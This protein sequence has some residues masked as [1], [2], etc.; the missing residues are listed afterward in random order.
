[1]RN[2]AKNGRSETESEEDILGSI[3]G[4]MVVGLPRTNWKFIH[5][6]CTESG[7]RSFNKFL[8]LF[9]KEESKKKRYIISHQIF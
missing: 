3:T 5:H 2:L 4:A 6:R 7:V 1:M 8:R 9:S